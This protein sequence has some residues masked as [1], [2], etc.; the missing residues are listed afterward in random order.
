MRWM[1]E[2]VS[3]MYICIFLSV[4]GCL[5]QEKKMQ[6]PSVFVNSNGHHFWDGELPLNRRVNIKTASSQLQI[7]LV[8][9]R[10][11]IDANFGKQEWTL[12][13]SS[14]RNFSHCK[15]RTEE[16]SEDTSMQGWTS[17][18]KSD[19]YKYILNILENEL[20]L[21]GF[22]TV[23]DLSDSDA[24]RANIHDRENGGYVG[25]VM[26]KNNNVLTLRYTT[27][28]RPSSGPEGG[29][30]PLGEGRSSASNS[31]P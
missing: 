19:N 26:N 18:L 30:E 7:A 4:S 6:E 25:I 31:T 27:G 23:I 1:H 10:D 21:Y 8:R 14:D 11:R 5:K 2:K 15:D 20:R 22:K 29:S 17:G 9:V 24:Y 13:D 16:G 12:V 3:C 28:C